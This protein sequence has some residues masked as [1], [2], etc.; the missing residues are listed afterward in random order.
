MGEKGDYTTMFNTGTIKKG[1]GHQKGVGV[2]NAR[3]GRQEVW[4]PCPLMKQ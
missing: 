4:T 3:Y 2:G 1:G